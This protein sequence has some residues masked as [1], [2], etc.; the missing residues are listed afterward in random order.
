[1]K[2]LLMC[3][4]AA[5]TAYAQALP[6]M[7]K[8]GDAVQLIVD[9][10]P[11]L[12]LSGE[13]ANTAPS[14]LD[15][16]QRIFPIL[17]R[18]VHLNT[19]LT[20]MAWA[21][22]EPREGDYDFHFAD[23]AIEN[24][25]KC[26]LRIA[27]LW[28]GSWKNGQSNFVPAWVKANQDRFPRAQ[29][30]NG[31]SVETLSTLSE[32]N[33]QADARA[34]A[35]LMR[36]VRE[37]D[38]N[39]RVLMVQVENEVGLLGDSRDRSPVA[40]QAFGKPVPAEFLDYLQKHK[41]NLLPEFRKIWE[42][43][44][45]K[46]SGT[47]EEVFGKGVQTDEIFMGWNYARYV[48]KVTEAGKREY[49]IP[50]FVNAWL[51]APADRGPGDYPSGGPQAHMHDIW[52][53]GAPHVDMLCP[54]IYMPNF[55]E[56]AA[57]FS[58]SGN[59][60]FIP[61][62]AG[63]I[64][65]AANA[66]YAIGQHKAVGYSSMGIGELQR[67]TAFRASDA[68]PQ[69]PT[70]I[71]NLPLPAA[72]ATLAQ[73]A[74][75]VLE[76]QAKGTIAGA[77]L[78]KDNPDTRIKLGGNILNVSLWGWGRRSVSDVPIGQGAS[79]LK[80]FDVVPDLT[81]YGIFMLTGPDEFLMAGDNLQI[82]FSPDPPGPEFVGLAEQEAGRFENGQWVHIRYLAGD[83]STLRRDFANAVALGQSGFGV[84]LF[85]QPHLSFAERA[86]QRVKV[87]RYK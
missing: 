13:L 63:D 65:G 43:G 36:H 12:A 51:N 52:R 53:A 16:M 87:Y 66:F 8:R 78:N 41:D 74:P 55:A 25:N 70:D 76:H 28:F 75:L 38:K 82:T 69:V 68:G 57:R 34:F 73:L 9:G 21:W 50:M 23:A 72:Y 85:A 31:K 6:H 24:A 46:T 4:L 59:P 61:E 80:P 44:G 48:D 81:G 32:S 30:Q 3:A 7:E 5:A 26:N 77:W 14:D 37:V 11:F 40:N 22:I 84:R 29:I 86:I 62:S 2:T 39:R 18:Q 83:D 27:W 20:A 35:A 79:T 64:H 42:A 49:P 19:V 1:M 10:K 67:L 45:F 17:A 60:L 54:D 47:W 33:W 15:Y 71:E 56:L 58:R